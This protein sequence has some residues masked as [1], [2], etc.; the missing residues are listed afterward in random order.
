MAK[1]QKINV[2]SNLGERHPHRIILKFALELKDKDS[3]FTINSTA[4]RDPNII[5]GK[6]DIRFDSKT[7]ASR[8]STISKLVYIRYLS[9]KEDISK[10]IDCLAA[11]IE[12]LPS[13]GRTFDEAL[14]IGISVLSLIHI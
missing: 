6:L 7:I 11:I 10:H 9:V 2:G 8:I 14:A 13:M 4:I 5:M 3:L 12:K 1:S